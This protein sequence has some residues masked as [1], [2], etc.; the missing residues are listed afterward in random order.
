MKQAF[1]QRGMGLVGVIIAAGLLGIVSLGVV[2]LI[3]YSSKQQSMSQAKDQQH[4]VTAL[5]RA[6]L[7][8]T[9][10]CVNTFQGVSVLPA[11]V[12]LTQI[13]D[14]ANT[15]QMAINTNDKSGMLRINQ[16]TASNWDQDPVDPLIGRMDLRLMLSRLGNSTEIKPDIITLY[17][18]KSAAHAVLECYALGI[19]GGSVADVIWSRNGL[20]DI[21]YNGGHVGVGM[22]TPPPEMLTVAGNIRLNNATDKILSHNYDI[23][24]GSTSPIKLFESAT[25]ANG[26][27]SIANGVMYTNLVNGRSGLG[28]STP[29]A[30]LDVNGEVKFGNTNSVCDASREGQQRYNSL[31]KLMQYCDGTAWK[32]FTTPTPKDCI[33]GFAPCISG[34]KTYMVVQVAEP[35]GV[36]CSP[37]FEGETST[38]GCAAPA[39]LGNWTACSAGFQTY[40]GGISPPCV[41][42]NGAVR[43]CGTVPATMGCPVGWTLNG[44]NCE[45]APT[46]PPPTYQIVC[47]PVPGST[48]MPIHNQAPCTGPGSRLCQY[49]AP[50]TQHVCMSIADPVDGSGTGDCISPGSCQQ[51][52]MILPECNDGGTLTGP[53]PRRCVQPATMTCPA[54]HPI[55]NGSTCSL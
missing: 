24:F 38:V 25:V 19:T 11:V 49:S 41:N 12:N 7:S 55:Q 5:A 15:V 47:A 30:K 23:P 43:A 6:I 54:S 35:G 3:S 21:Y 18:R 8:N 37:H 46:I 1:N 28:T 34:V 52:G 13:K 33:G 22:N 51:S 45:Q 4:E 50:S 40:Y 9:T 2:E 42:A 16:I 17:V 29:S 36:S 10:A 44:S 27:I 48:P 53:S 39:C 32:N 31:T 14:A 26:S 20:I